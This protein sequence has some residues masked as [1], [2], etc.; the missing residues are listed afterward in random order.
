M[1]TP[2][3]TSHAVAQ[4]SVT[5]YGSL[6]DGLVYVN[7][8]SSLG[9]TAGGKSVNKFV[10]GIL[11]GSKFGLIGQEDLGG[12]TKAI[13]RLESGF[14]I[15]TGSAQFANELF[16]YVADVGIT[17]NI[18]GTVTAGRQYTPY[19][20]LLSPYSPT[21]WL[22]GFTGAHPGDVDSMDNNYRMNNSLV[23]TSPSIYGFTMSGAYALG[24]VAGSIN[25][26]STWSLALQY[27]NGPF[28]LAAAVLR[29]NNSNTGGGDWGAASTTNSNGQIGVSAITNGYQTAAAQQRLAVTGGYEFTQNLGISMQYTNVQYVPGVNSKFRD[30][31]IFNTVGAVLHYLVTPSILLATGY[32]YTRATKANGIDAPAQYH[33]FSLRESYSLSK[34]TLFYALQGIQVA[35]GKTLGTPGSGSVIDATATVGDGFN[36]APSSSNRQFAIVFGINHKF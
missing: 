6:D 28:G 1:L 32:S 10:N 17:N 4:T 29:I 2:C 36:G 20:V 11:T 3:V 31:A 18:L 14:N 27:L 9:S 12:G 34:S 5:L 30:E 7:N 8:Q 35:Q 21:F 19:W 26:G 25:T 13:F 16:G 23:Y 22:T 15:D 33:Q 24:G